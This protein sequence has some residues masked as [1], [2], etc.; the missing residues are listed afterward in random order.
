MATV[1]FNDQVFI[2][3]ALQHLVS[4]LAPVKI[5][6][7]DLSA[8]AA[9]KGNALLVPLVSNVTATTFNQSYTNTGGTLAAVTVT[10]N[11]H[12]IATVSLTDAQMMNSSPAQFDNFAF[13]IAKG[14]SK[15]VLQDIWSCITTANGFACVTT[16]AS[17]SWAKATAQKMRYTL[18][19]NDVDPMGRSLVLNAVSSDALIGDSNISQVYQYGGTEAIRDGKITRLLGFDVHESNIIPT[20][21]ISLNAF[22][23]HADAVCVAMRS[24]ASV[25]PDGAYEAILP[26]SDPDS[27]INFTWR[28]VYDPLTGT[29]YFNAECL[30]GYTVALTR[31]L[32]LAVTPTT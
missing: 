18:N 14:L 17:A 26:A 12:R 4:Q 23:C 9:N 10:L 31:N 13:Q 22:A 1:T 27:G 30:F 21:S 2:Q 24:L 5:F 32:C 7:R 19:A 25:V 8:Q 20:N 3:E 11:Q 29:H 16:L 28:R 15:L 6:T